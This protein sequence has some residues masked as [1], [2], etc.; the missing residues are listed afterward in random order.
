MKGLTTLGLV[1][2]ATN[3][4]GDEPITFPDA[5][6]QTRTPAQVGLNVVR[7]QEFRAMVGG[8]GAIVRNGYMVYAWGNQNARN[9]QGWASASKAVVSTML[10]FAINEGR[11]N[12][13]DV[14]VRSYVQQQFPNRDLIVKD[15]PMTFNHLANG[16]SGYALPEAPGDAWAYNDHGFKLYKYLVFGQLFGVSPTNASAVASQITSPARLGPLQFQNGSLIVIAKGAPRWNAT[17][18]DTARLGWFWLNKGRWKQQQLLPQSMFDT[19]VR[20]QVP[21]NL[22]RSTSHTPNDY[23]RIGT[24]GDNDPNQTPTDPHYGYNWHHNVATDGSLD[25]PNAPDDLF[26]AL[27]NLNKCI[28][29]VPSQNLVAVWRDG[30]NLTDEQRA[31]AL[32]K[33]SSAVIP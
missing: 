1:M 25:V 31:S 32:E 22:P 19:Y 18:R 28:V 23:L 2:L 26:Y 3:V 17:I 30:F 29:M 33:L 8:S 9:W 6:W 21:A 14:T 5:Q 20:A 10:F 27:G 12:T 15:R 11:L 16:L 4:M 13:P 24:D 7:L